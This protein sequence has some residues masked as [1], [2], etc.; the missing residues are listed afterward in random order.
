[1]STGKKTDWRN[2]SHGPFRRAKTI[3]VTG[4]KGGVGKTSV[5]LKLSKTLAKEGKKVLLIDCDYNLSN[6]AVK[7]GI[8]L[9][10]NFKSFI[11]GEKR[12]EDCLY[13]DGNL[14]LLSGCNGSLELFD[15]GSD[16]EKI[17]LD[18]LYSHEQHYD[19]IF[20]DCPAGLSRETLT[21][22]AY[23]DERIV[24]VVPDKS[25]ITDAYS[26]IKI[27]NN[28]YGVRDNFLL[29]NR[30]SNQRQFKRLVKTMSETI[31]KYLNSNIKILGNVRNE[32]SISDQ[33]D[34]LLLGEESD[35]HKDFCKIIGRLTEDEGYM[36]QTDNSR[37][38]KGVS[39]NLVERI[40][41]KE[42]RPQL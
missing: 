39:E 32:N 10:D 4:G 26:L 19:F 11:N 30:V 25:S 31:E 1:M 8:S 13:S 7:L 29:V 35:L 2:S 27:L 17:I 22:N 16:I 40:S 23:C 3:S 15:H 14:D 42:F 20:L 9:S 28:R 18:V 34:K 24:V 12:F 38:G 33:F 41:T 37:T 6:T 21:L 36:A 5:A